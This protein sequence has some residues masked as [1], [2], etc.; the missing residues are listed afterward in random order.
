MTTYYPQQPTDWT[1]GLAEVYNRQSRQLAEHHANLRQR[2]QEQV[3]VQKE[4]NFRD[5]LAQIAEFSTTAASLRNQMKENKEKKD[6]DTRSKFIEYLNLNPSHVDENIK[7]YNKGERNIW[8]DDKLGLQFQNKLIDNGNY[9][10]ANKLKKLIAS[11]QLIFNEVMA[12][13]MAPTIIG[14]PSFNEHLSTLSDKE[15]KEATSSPIYRQEWNNKQILTVSN[16]KEFTSKFLYPEVSRKNSTVQNLRKAKAQTQYNISQ[17][18]LAKGILNAKSNSPTSSSLAEGMVKMIQTQELTGGYEEVEGGPTIREQAVKD[19][20]D[21]FVQLNLEGYI[22]NSA[23]AGLDESLFPSGSIIQGYFAKDGSDLVRITRA[24]KIG[25]SKRLAVET[26]KDEAIALDIRRRKLDG[27]DVTRELQHLRSRGL[28]SDETIKAIEKTNPADNTQEAYNDESKYWNTSMQNGT[29]LSKENVDL[30]KSIKNEKLKAE[31]LQAQEKL[32]ASYNL[33]GFDSYEKRQRANGSLIMKQSQQRTLGENEVLE[34]FNERLQDEITNLESKLYM[35]YYTLNSN[36]PDIGI[37]VAIDKKKELTEKGFYATLG[38]ENEGIY[39]KDSDGN[40]TNYQNHLMG[41]IQ[42]SKLPNE[43]NRTNWSAQ[44]YN[45]WTQAS[46]NFTLTG[47]TV[48]ERVLNKVNST[49]TPQDI[50]GIFGSNEI[51]DKLMYIA[52]LFPNT[53]ETEILIGAT[54][55]LIASD[56]KEHQQIVKAF[57]LEKKLENIPT[58]QLKLKDKI[59]SINDF[60]LKGIIDRG[61]HKA[62]PKQK[63]RLYASLLEIADKSNAETYKDSDKSLLNN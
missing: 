31:V 61:L 20:V 42:S 41:Q 10:E 26:D 18:V 35:K 32:Q 17:D 46:N 37:K 7:K 23:L 22:P 36:D 50:I 5:T 28:V 15:L 45:S 57:K 52:T 11:N 1:K 33:N 53:N 48:K 63:E 25:Q 60:D 43:N 19:V 24:N 16:S 27:E 40:F 58:V 6:E 13:R 44:V 38:D 21:K 56:N 30:A 51:S 8:E 49:L 54:K 34:G 29:L 3:Q 4:E 59:K 14:D 47:D 12:E 2:D 55:A 9:E 62:S 39:T